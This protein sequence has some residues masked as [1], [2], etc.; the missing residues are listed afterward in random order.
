MKAVVVGAGI[1]GLS[2]ALYLQKK[3][4]QVTVLEKLDRPGGRARGFSHGEFSFDMGPSWYLMPE[5]FERF[6]R[7][8]GEELPRVKEV[9]PLFSLYTGKLNLDEKH[10]DFRK[11]SFPLSGEVK[12]YMDDTRFMYD[13][14]MER[15]L[16]KEM[17]FSD[18]LDPMILRNLGRF[19]IFSSLDSFN[20][21]YFTDD[22]SLK[23]MG[24]SS[25][26]LGGS[27]FNT[28]AVYAMVNYAIF[29]KGVYY[30]EGGFAGMVQRLYDLCKRAGV[31]FKFNH[32]VSKVDV[33]ESVVAVRSGDEREEGDVFIFNMDYH[34]A[35]TL[36][37]FEY[38]MRGESFWERKKLS[39]SAILAYL[40]VE[41]EVK[42]PHHTIVINGNWKVHFDSISQG[43]EPDPQNM[44]YYVSYRKA[45][46]DSLKGD[47]LVF[48]IPV[49][50]GLLFPQYQNFVDLV[51]KDFMVK[52]GSKFQVKFQ[53]VYRSINFEEDYNS[54]KG[55]A[56]G[57]SHTLDQ[58]GPFRLPMRNRKIPNLFYVGQ[59]TQP[60][61]GVPMVTI[62]S[63]IV[64]E[65]VL[66]S[67]KK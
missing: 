26:F 14:A 48:L 56:F 5:V 36:L 35:D 41:G 45:T 46:D 49:S 28:P 30:P 39:P 7:E 43:K 16:F 57:I 37:P 18:F 61:I 3:G 66:N 10:G 32:E 42:A 62:S 64:G 44:S 27:P 52:T 65:K 38:T 25:V 59:Y 63:M 23:S 33:D 8:V 22:F 15:F 4:L 12:K 20:R 34:Y 47:D 19:P 11:D 53:R 67:L 6:Y 60:G 9:D 21:K 51:V 2:T 17:K 58:T 1:G 40:G 54:Y 24:F 13:L 31:E 55:T 29:G 50:P